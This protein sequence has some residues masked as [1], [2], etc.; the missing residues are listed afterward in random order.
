MG[1]STDALLG[2]GIAYEEAFEDLYEIVDK[3]DGVSVDKRLR[4]LGVEI[5]LHCSSDY[6]CPAFSLFDYAVCAHRGFPRKV[7]LE[8]PTDPDR[9]VK[10]QNGIEA[11]KAL[12]SSTGDCSRAWLDEKYPT[13]NAEDLGF[14]L[15]SDRS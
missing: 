9:V 6:P 11:W 2:W 10:L 12:M 4:D 1:I 7:V 15:A 14:W 3:L 8:A 13:P 5:V